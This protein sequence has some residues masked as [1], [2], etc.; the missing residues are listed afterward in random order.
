MKKGFA[1]PEG[2][3]TFFELHPLHEDKL[4]SF[5]DLLIS[6][7]GF[8]TYLG[9]ADDKSD[10]D[11][12]K[13]LITAV[14]H[15][16]N[17]I[18]TA[19]N[20][21]HQK[22]EKIVGIAIKE[23]EEIGVQRDQ[24]II[25]S[26]GGYIPA[27]ESEDSDSALKHY[28]DQGVISKQ[29]VVDDCHCIAPAFIQD[30]IDKSLHNLKLETI[31]LY[32]L[33]NP[34]VQLFEI[35][36]IQFEERMLEA[37]LLLEENVRAG[38]IRN[39][40]LATWNGFRQKANT[41]GL[42]QLHKLVDIAL[43]IAGSD[44]HF[45][46]VQLP[47]NLVMLEGAKMANQELDEEFHTF[48]HTASQLGMELF[49]SSPLMQQKVLHLPNRVF[50]QLPVEQTRQLQA[51]QFVCSTPAVTSALV[52]MKHPSHVQENLHLLLRPN[53]KDDEWQAVKSFLH[54]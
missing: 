16:V 52:G 20:Y 53:W 12:L 8:G 35:S 48:F 17:F 49:I 41:K 13:S 5:G 36:D 32:Y 11:Y 47:Y 7:L 19:I 54:L 18:D 25:A 33:H 44:H 1:T 39:Y 51:L 31:D 40:G 27:T 3:R 10:E 15:G 6:S 37:F 4:R 30:Q 45:K 28:L 21:R 14:M 22:S 26:K 2:T 34:E 42:L 29:D 46:A 23:L 43:K 9:A 38:K 24:L 50:E